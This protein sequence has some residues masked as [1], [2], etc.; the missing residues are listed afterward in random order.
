MNRRPA[1]IPAVLLAFL[2]SLSATGCASKTT[3]SGGRETTV[4]G[5][6]VTVA[7]NSF[8][9]PTPATIDT[10]TSKI[11]GK[12]GPSGR[13]VSLLWGLLTFNDY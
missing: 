9:P 5:G 8:Q 2:L 3:A 11:A 10:D 13:K 6:A 12:D 1:P 4:L 7:S